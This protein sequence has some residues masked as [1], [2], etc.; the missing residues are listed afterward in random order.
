[1]LRYLLLKC[2]SNVFFR[3]AD[4]LHINGIGE[5]A[6]FSYVANDMWSGGSVHSNISF[7]ELFDYVEH[8][9]KLIVVAFIKGI[10]N[11]SNVNVA[12][13]LYEK[14]N[15]RIST[16]AVRIGIDFVIDNLEP[17]RLRRPCNLFKKTGCDL[18]CRL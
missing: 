5:T 11:D 13:T 17:V 3:G 6:P 10:E 15:D 14:V 2:I 16:W 7:D 18:I 4:I 12:R 9:S 1:V 8:S